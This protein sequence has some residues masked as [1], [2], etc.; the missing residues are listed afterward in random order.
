MLRRRWIIALSV[1]AVAA[2]KS[3]KTRL[4]EDMRALQDR[5]LAAVHKLD[6]HTDAVHDAERRIEKMRAELA[7]CN[8]GMR[9]FLTSHPVASACIRASRQSWGG[10]DSPWANEIRPYTRVT[11]ALCNAA[12]LNNEF[13]REIDAVTNRLRQAEARV[14]ELNAQIAELQRS[15]DA[16]R[17][18]LRN[19]EAEVDRLSAEIAKIRGR[20]GE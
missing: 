3:E 15:A 13:A 10:D 2:C 17:S 20:L 7:T 8:A 9:E 4:S 1:L 5:H 12:L 19:D 16:Q 6:E 18:E 11:A 14:K